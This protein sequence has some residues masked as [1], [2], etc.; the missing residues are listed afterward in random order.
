M[1]DSIL[2]SS[3][4][5]TE[6]TMKKVLLITAFLSIFGITNAL[7]GSIQYIGTGTKGE[8]IKV[9]FSRNKGASWQN[10]QVKMGQTFNVPRDAT[11]L[12]IN[13]VPYD[14]KKNYKIRDGH[15][16]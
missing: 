5:L 4:E 6:D 2:V 12:T 11:H 13:N 8:P 14:P 1:A 10:V 3:N 9:S 16:Y 15:V 7:A